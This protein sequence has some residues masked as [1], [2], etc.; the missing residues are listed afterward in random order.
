MGTGNKWRVGDLVNLEGDTL[1][2]TYRIVSIGGGA[3]FL[4]EHFTDRGP[5]KTTRPEKL[6]P[7]LMTCF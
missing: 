3:L 4:R 5:Y 7:A 6:V 1:K 2:E